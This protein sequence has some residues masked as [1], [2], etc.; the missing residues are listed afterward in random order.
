METQI[1]QAV[2]Q[3]SPIQRV[4]IILLEA[5]SLKSLEMLIHEG[6]RIKAFP[7]SSHPINN[8]FSPAASE[9]LELAVTLWESYLKVHQVI[10][11]DF[12]LV[13]HLLNIMGQFRVTVA[14]VYLMMDLVSL[15]PLW[16]YFS[17]TFLD[18]ESSK[19]VIGFKSKMLLC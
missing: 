7:S 9:A 1:L 11:L 13:L 4:V 17:I 5:L 16:L 8:D 6:S 3:E 10:Q 15:S 14:F 2:L 18:F 12:S 19:I